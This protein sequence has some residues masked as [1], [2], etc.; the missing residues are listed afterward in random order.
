MTARTHR[1]ER[2]FDPPAVKQFF[3]EVVLRA[4]AKFGFRL[5]NFCLMGNHFHLILRPREGTSLSRIMQWILSV[6]AMAWNRDQGFTGQGA[7]WGQRFFSTILA[8]LAHYLH[9]FLYIDA[10]PVAAGLASDP[11]EWEFDGP[12]LRR[13]CQLPL[14]E[15]PLEDVRPLVLR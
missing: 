7:V 1:G 13:H 4:K 5:E 15:D 10:N 8:T 3:L 14:L 12:Y 9:A 2:I 11:E 6:F